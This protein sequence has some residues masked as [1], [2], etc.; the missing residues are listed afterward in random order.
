MH[1]NS[2]KILFLIV[3]LACYGVAE[4][5]SEEIAQPSGVI[6]PKSRPEKL[7]FSPDGKLLVTAEDDNADVSLWYVETSALKVRLRGGHRQEWVG[8]L[9][10]SGVARPT[11]SPDGSTLVVMDFRANEIR[12]WDVGT[13]KLDQL[14]KGGMGMQEPVFSPDGRLLA[15]AGLP[16]LKLWDMKTRQLRN[17]SHADALGTNRVVFEPDGQAFWA[18]VGSGKKLPGQFSLYRVNLVTGEVMTKIVPADGKY[19][20]FTLSPDGE[21]LATSAESAGAFKLWKVATGEMIATLGSHKNDIGLIAFSPNRQTLTTTD[22]KKITLWK[23]ESAELIVS[24]EQQFG[25]VSRFSPDGSLLAI[26]VGQGLSLRDARTGE[27]KQLLKGASSPFAF[28]RDG[29]LLATTGKDGSVS[30][31]RI[32]HR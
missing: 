16:G 30:I 8:G 26:V 2:E 6:K 13:G 21:T 32:L 3:A 11:F 12:L 14:F 20:W 1:K 15:L 25:E 5:Q 27:P 31:W 18:L 19:F 17:W 24:L 28:N 9:A 4:G 7:V 22:G 10:G 23:K 29:D